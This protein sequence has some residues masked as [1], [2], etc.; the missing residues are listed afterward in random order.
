MKKL[1]K[2]FMFAG[3]MALGLTPI[4]AITS[5]GSPTTEQ[6][7]PPPPSVDDSVS[8]E[9]LNLEGAV[10]DLLDTVD[11]ITLEDQEY[12]FIEH[13]GSFDNEIK[14]KLF[15]EKGSD[16][17]YAT[18][19]SI[20]GAVEGG[21]FGSQVEFPELVSTSREDPNPQIIVK[22]L[23]LPNKLPTTAKE[24]DFYAR[25]LVSNKKVP[26]IWLH[27][28]IQYIFDGALSNMHNNNGGPIEIYGCSGVKYIGQGAFYNSGLGST[29][30]AEWFDKKNLL[31]IAN[32]AFYNNYNLENIYLPLTVQ[33][34]GA[35]ALASTPKFK[36]ARFPLSIKPDIPS[37]FGLE[38]YNDA[39]LEQFIQEKIRWTDDILPPLD[40][41]PQEETQN[42]EDPVNPILDNSVEAT[43]EQGDEKESLIPAE[44][45]AK[46]DYKQL[47]AIKS[48][49]GWGHESF[50]K[51]IREKNLKNID[52]T[53]EA[54]SVTPIAPFNKEAKRSNVMYQLT[55][56]SFA[57]GDNDG[58]GDFWGLT[59][60]LNYFTDLGIDT[61]YLSP[62]HPSSSYHGY[63]VIDYTD[64]APELGGMAAFDTFMN[65]AH[66][67]GIRVVMDMVFNHTS[68]E[69]PWFQKALM[70][71]P[72]YQGFY[73][74]YDQ[75]SGYKEGY[76][77]KELRSKFRNVNS[78]ED[79]SKN[80]EPSKKYW[81]SE[82]GPSMPDLNLT[83]PKV[84]EQIGNIH[85]FWAAKGV[86]GFRYDAFYHYFEESLTGNNKKPHGEYRSG[87][88]LKLFQDW[89]K[90][91]EAEYLVA[92][93][94]G[95]PRSSERS[96]MFG[97]WW[98]DPR[99]AKKYWGT[100]DNPGLSS[101][102]D[103]NRWKYNNN[104]YIQP[105]DTGWGTR[106]GEQPLIHALNED[107]QN[108]EW[109]PFLD[110]HDVERWITNLQQTAL[111]QPVYATANPLNDD[112][113]A[114]YE[115]ALFSLLSRGGL[116]TLYDGNELLMHGGKKANNPDTYVREAFYWKDLRRRVFFRDERS[117]GD[118]IS[119][120]G[121]A[122][123]GFVEDI[124]A[125]ADSSYNKVKTIINARKEYTSMREAETKYVAGVDDV[126]YVWN[127]KNIR[128]EEMTLR[129]NDDGT[130][131]L[132]IY[133]WG[134]R[135]ECNTS[136][137][138]EY[139]V[140]EIYATPDLK[141]GLNEHNQYLIQG[142][143]TN[144]LGIYKISPRA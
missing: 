51:Q 138:S 33:Y 38:S 21:W 25:S 80:P 63:D 119:T 13:D 24:H 47:K 54:N 104:V 52:Y 48:F 144:R 133:S 39:T 139:K 90:I 8:E 73:Y 140:D 98:K 32:R 122:G 130:Y 35:K 110:N 137:K 55:V 84:L 126:L 118:I 100:P 3:V 115:Y 64:V 143:G 71:D 89:R 19:T 10:N 79:P 120:K 117:P 132:V 134:K 88:T 121:S 42:W 127:D 50:V 81:V 86:D 23:G 9:G 97:E 5:C 41:K 44:E 27:E 125:K 72:E 114:A 14:F 40:E 67:R 105:F 107:G 113:V 29:K 78:F 56:Y 45:Y 77:S 91:V 6:F 66:K 142:N 103:G 2:F 62:I 108:H 36:R 99:D 111:H 17:K 70:G 49:R 93:E 116:P 30:S 26:K 68:Y 4:T 57:D 28:D 69:H 74:M 112:A 106:D 37:I 59:K 20:N 46:E 76:D 109:M 75:P 95:I 31:Y 123:N 18:I 83:N 58:I 43:P 136:F 129:K 22:G 96:F 128:R 131:I 102:I 87:E 7:L 82:F 135:G 34:V 124:M 92:Q 141:L 15:T 53:D 101:V 12:T 94:Q 11:N 61:L 65:E 60:E 85:K 16:V 1:K